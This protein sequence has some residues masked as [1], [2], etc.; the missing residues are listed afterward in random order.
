MEVS[1]WLN[2]AEPQAK[3]YMLPIYHR[4][5]SWVTRVK[6]KGNEAE[7]GGGSVTGCAIKL[8]TT[9]YQMKHSRSLG[10]IFWEFILI[11][12]CKMLYFIKRRHEPPSNSLQCSVTITQFVFH[13]V[14]VPHTHTTYSCPPCTW[15]IEQSIKE[16]WEK[17]L[18]ILFPTG[19]SHG[20]VIPPCLL[21]ALAWVP[22][23]LV[24][25][26]L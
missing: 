22:S 12:V 8:A 1:L 18:W 3:V 13:T 9:C 4:V 24:H 19:L 16:Q 17:K 20:I 10:T 11:S 15:F 21:I 14:F 2:E 5:K 23:S 7:N 6:K 26:M 25:L